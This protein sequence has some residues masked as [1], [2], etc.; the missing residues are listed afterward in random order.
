MGNLIISTKVTLDGVMEVG[1]WF[2][3]RG[4]HDWHGATGAA[5]HDQ[6]RAT[7]AMLLG[8]KNYEGLAA[9]WP[10]MTDDV[11]FADRVNSMRKFVV[12]RTLQEP[13]SWNATL[14]EGDMPDGVAALKERTSGNL[15][16]MDVVNSPT[17]SSWKAWSTSSDS[18]STRMCGGAAS[19]RSTDVRRF[20]WNW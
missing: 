19:G 20:L 17:S 14:L 4:E 10:T 2:R 9:V 6:L 3:S 5:S 8:C 15:L 12:S 11:G 13:L 16:P 18:G 1:E 7:E